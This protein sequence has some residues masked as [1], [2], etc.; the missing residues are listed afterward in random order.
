MSVMEAGAFRLGDGHLEGGRRY[1]T[2]CP[3]RERQGYLGLAQTC[4][5]GDPHGAVEQA[6]SAAVEG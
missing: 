5:V 4:F 3:V 1:L 6:A 2:F